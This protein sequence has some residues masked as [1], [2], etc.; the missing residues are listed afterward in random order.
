MILQTGRFDN[1][2]SALIVDF[3]KLT[4]LLTLPMM[5]LN[6]CCRNVQFFHNDMVAFAL[7]R[8]NV[9]VMKQQEKW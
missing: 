6:L 1:I 8:F 4:A 7:Q 2:K 5:N 9:K 3:V